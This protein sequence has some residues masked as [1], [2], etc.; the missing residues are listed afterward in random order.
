[1]ARPSTS[2]GM[3]GLPKARAKLTS[4]RTYSDSAAAPD[5]TSTS[6]TQDST[7]SR[8]TSAHRAPRSISSSTHT[9][10]RRWRIHATRRRT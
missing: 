10:T 6:T 9:S 7:R 2:S 3:I 1:M 4:R 5:I 8:S